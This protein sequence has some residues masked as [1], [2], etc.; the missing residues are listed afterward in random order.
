MCVCIYIY[1]DRYT[2]IHKS[3]YGVEPD[4]Q[5]PLPAS[6][7]TMACPH[8]N[9]QFFE[10]RAAAIAIADGFAIAA[11]VIHPDTNKET[12]N[13]EFESDCVMNVEGGCSKRVV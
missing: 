11:A 5:S 2:H 13:S 1:I 4:F 6:S 12:R 9:S 7:H 3:L 10:F 8:F